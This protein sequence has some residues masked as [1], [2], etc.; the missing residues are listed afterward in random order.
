M[1]TCEHTSFFS[2]RFIGTVAWR[3]CRVAHAH[4]FDVL[5]GFSWLGTHACL[6]VL[7]SHLS[8]RRFGVLWCRSVGFSVEGKVQWCSA[9]GGLIRGLGSSGGVDW[10]VGRP[11]AGRHNSQWWFRSAGLSEG[12]WGELGRSVGLRGEISGSVGI[13]CGA[14][15]MLTSLP[16]GCD[17]RS[18]RAVGTPSALSVNMKFQRDRIVF[19]PRWL[20]WRWSRLLVQRLERLDFV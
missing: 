17:G 12:G 14:L 20:W 9:V 2:F 3:R 6:L 13:G 8:A 10:P 11:I 18:D 16:A 1:N 15:V 4:E 5:V 7:G 19:L